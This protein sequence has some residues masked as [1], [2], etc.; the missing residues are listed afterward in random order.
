MKRFGTGLVV[1]KFCPLHRGH[2]VVLDSATSQCDRLVVIS[3]T[4]PEFDGC[5]ADRREQWLATLY[6]DAIRLVID[7]ARLSMHCVRLGVA[8]RTLPDN[9]AP[10]Q[11]HRAFV[12]WL[13]RVVLALDV[14]AVFTSEAYGDGFAVA[15]SEAQGRYVS[16]VSCDP[17]RATIPVSG[18]ALRGDIHALRAH[19]HPVVYRDFVQRVAILGGESTGKS[20]M[21]AR[22]AHALGTVHAEEYGRE[23]WELKGGELTPDE[24]ARVTAAVSKEAARLRA[25]ASS[26]GELPPTTDASTLA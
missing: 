17:E 3:Y 23:L 21:A 11:V 7:D 1:G 22:L 25:L 12:A 8:P 5:A 9:D 14:D 18:T 16:H 6:P 10:D 2:Q 24:V 19:V 15:L 4:K 26:L 13:L 20:M